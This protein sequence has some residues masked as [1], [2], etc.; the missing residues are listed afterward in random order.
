[1]TTNET[2][3]C[4]LYGRVPSL[5]RISEEALAS[6]TL[7]NYGISDVVVR[8]LFDLHAEIKM[9]ETFVAFLRHRKRKSVFGR[10]F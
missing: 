8:H 7:E 5:A 10:V 2:R 3:R 6:R 4:R 9:F 1:M